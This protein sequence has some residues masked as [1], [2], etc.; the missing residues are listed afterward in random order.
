MLM[1]MDFPYKRIMSEYERIYCSITSIYSVTWKK[2]IN[3]E[4][5]FLQILVE[6]MSIKIKVV[7]RIE[8]IQYW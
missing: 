7:R 4:F 8:Q 3:K 1:I 6:V 2:Y 5:L